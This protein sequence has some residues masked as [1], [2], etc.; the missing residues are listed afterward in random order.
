MELSGRPAGL[1][2]APTQDTANNKFTG[3]LRDNESGPDYFGARYFSGAQGR[4][5]SA[6]WSAKPEAVP[7]ASLGDPQSLNLYAYVRNNPLSRTDLDG[8]WDCSGKNASGI[9]CQFIAKWNAVRGIAQGLTG[10]GAQLLNDRLQRIGY[11][12]AAA[13]LSGPGASAERKVLQ[14]ATY[15]KLS[16]VGQSITDAA[17]AARAGQL[18]GKTAEQLM[19]SAPRTSTAINALGDVSAT[20]GAVGVVAG[21]ASVA[22]ETSNAPPGQK[23][24][25]ALG[26]GERLGGSLAGAW[27]GAEVGTL[28]GPW[29]ALIGSIL[30][31]MVGTEAVKGF[32]NAPPMS[33]ETR[34]G[35]GLMP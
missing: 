3:K 7:Y 26:G 10:T 31:G 12:N 20:A 33:E 32:Q 1:L 29:G 21:V 34:N 9:G 5:T 27:A 2:A 19:E 30:G 24:D 28:G 18:A 22:L 25:T 4:F 13:K 11:K 17:K 23:L 14:A 16:S 15:S 6:D 8:H 35:L